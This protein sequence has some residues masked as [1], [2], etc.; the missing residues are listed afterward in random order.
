M[1]GRA[2]S[3]E[4]KIN[5]VDAVI[6][7]CSGADLI[8]AIKAGGQ[9]IENYAKINVEKTFS[10]KSK[11]GAGLG[12]SIKTVVS[13]AT[14]TDVDVDIGSGLVYARAQELGAIILPIYAKMLSWVADS[15]ERIFANR[16]QIPARPYLRP[17]VDEHKSEIGDA[18]GIQLKKGI[19]AV[20]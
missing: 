9:V 15:G 16:V 3:V 13:K 19:E 1:T 2:G 8:R 17:A 7:A 5:N 20:T 12:G 4:I 11:G 14:D 6:A 18:I 10:G